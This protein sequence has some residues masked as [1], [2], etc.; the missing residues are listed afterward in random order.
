MRATVCAME[1]LL[2][3]GTLREKLLTSLLGGHYASRFR[4]DWV[5][6]CRGAPHFFNHRIGAFNFGFGKTF[7]AHFSFYRGFFVSEL[8]REGDRLLDVGC[9][10]GFFTKRFFAFKCS[11]VDAL[12]VERDAIE[13]AMRYNAA[14]NIRYWQRDA[15]SEPFPQEGYDVIVWDG[16][17]GHFPADSTERMLRKIRDA[18]NSGGVFCGSESLGREEGHDHLQFFD[19]LKDLRR[20]FEPYFRHVELRSVAYPGHPMSDFIRQEAYW[21]CANDPDRLNECKWQT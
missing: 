14:A 6:L 16:A 12:D 13:A 11:H 1:G 5:W 17:I 19:S 9:G 7:V 2:Y 18:L 10:D 20:I 15:V 4:R 21:R 3:G 8:I